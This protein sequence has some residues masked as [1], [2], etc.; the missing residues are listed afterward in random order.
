MRGFSDEERDRIR[1]ALREAG[2]EQF[3]R[4]G[5]RKTTIADLTDAVG[6][7]TSTFYRF[8]DSKEALYLAVLE[9]EGERIERRMAEAGVAEGD[10]P[11]AVVERFLRF[12]FEEIE[13]NPLVRRLVV[14]GDL[15]RLREHRTAAEREA[16]RRAEIAAIRSF[17]DRFVDAGTV[18]GDD[19][20]LVASAVAAVP[21][22]SLHEEEIG[23]ERYPEVR[24]FVVET[25]A[26]GLA[27]TDE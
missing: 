25:F 17:V 20:E 26:R 5:L 15:D 13:T 11:R 10:D 22:L 9:S 27:T 3:A 4:Y 7:G 23:P 19:P 21:Y 1:A 8:F 24:E 12:L 18:R 16:E 2:R 6:I 14:S